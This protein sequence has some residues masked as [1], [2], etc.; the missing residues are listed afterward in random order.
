MKNCGIG[1]YKAGLSSEIMF[2]NY[3]SKRYKKWL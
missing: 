2:L 3:K 1:N